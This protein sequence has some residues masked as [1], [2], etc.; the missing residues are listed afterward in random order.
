MT[1]VPVPAVSSYELLTKYPNLTPS[2]L[3]DKHRIRR[4]EILRDFPAPPVEHV[5]QVKDSYFKGPQTDI[6]LRIYTPEGTDP[7]PAVVFF[8]GG[9]WLLGDLDT[10]DALCRSMCNGT[11][12]VVISV[13][14]RVS[15]EARFPA[16]HEDSY[17]AFLHVHANAALYNI[18]PERI[19]VSGD[20]AGGNLS[21]A[22]CL[23]S[24][25]RNGPNVKFQCLMYPV[26]D[27]TAEHSK[28]KSGLAIDCP[29]MLMK[30]FI[31]AYVDPKDYENPY[32]SP[33]KANLENLPPA[34]ILT[35]GLDTLQHEG[36]ELAE[37]L[38]KFG[39][40]CK[41]VH[42]GGFDHSFISMGRANVGSTIAA[43]YQEATFM[44]FKFALF[45]GVPPYDPLA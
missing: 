24:R 39:V 15:A 11:G 36:I 29:P 45:K 10:Y 5:H 43:K 26:A 31:D 33:V 17:A 30:Y 38:V 41:H 1:P 32:L 25:D 9:G 13:G 18:D 20:S 12:A 19:A 22:T 35:C 44:S 8:H 34:F 27:V 2:E 4:Q 3:C 40:P 7:L 37:K 28:D 23:M 42:A 6:P 21:I 16:A 14:Y